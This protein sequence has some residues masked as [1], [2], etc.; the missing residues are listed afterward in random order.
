MRGLRDDHFHRVRRGAVDGAHLE[1]IADPA[2]HVDRIGL[3]D[4]QDEDVSG[5]D[6]PGVDGGGAATKDVRPDEG[7]P[8][9]SRNASCIAIFWANR[10]EGFPARNIGT[11]ERSPRCFGIIRPD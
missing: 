2:E 3:A 1:A 10:S 5:A 7:V 4:Q 6:G 11:S 9:R 8:R